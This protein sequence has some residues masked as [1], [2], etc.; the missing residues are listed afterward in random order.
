MELG[1]LVA[2]RRLWDPRPFWSAIMLKGFALVAADMPALRRSYIRFPW[3]H[4]YEHRTSVATLTV[5]REH[6]GEAVVAFAHTRSPE[7]WPLAALDARLRHCKEAP[8]ASLPSF[9][10]TLRLATLPWPLQR[11][12]IWLG[13]HASGRLRERFCGTFGL[14]STAGLG[15][16]LENVHSGL[17]ATLH[18]G[19]FDANGGVDMRLT[20][21]HRV[22]DGA[23]AARALAAME[24][25]L[26]G[27]LLEELRRPVGERAA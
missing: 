7:T 2:A 18:Y 15:A 5:D 20:F 3:A 8:A 22:F 23:T 12:A 27:P 19:Q 17:T 25:T 24:D 13:L 26:R 9:R 6:E 10:R 16:G 1:A 21:D 4:F 11:F 14:T